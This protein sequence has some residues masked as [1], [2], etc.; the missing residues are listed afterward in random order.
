MTHAM[1]LVAAEKF[2]S[3]EQLWFWFLYSK[4]VRNNFSRIHTVQTRRPC[5]MLDVETLITRLY[6][7]GKLTDEQLTACGINPAM[8][9]VSCGLENIDDII[10]DFEQALS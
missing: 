6:L 8:V 10:A 7:C 3:S 5:E 4:S 2:Q 1:A 9:R